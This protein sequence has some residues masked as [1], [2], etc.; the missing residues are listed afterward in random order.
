MY[1][2]CEP[3]FPS[4]LF[5]TIFT[6]IYFKQSFAKTSFDEK[7]QGGAKYLVVTDDS[8]WT[9]VSTI[10]PYEL[11]ENNLPGRNVGEKKR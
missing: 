8:I 2:E 11:H 10:F 4:V 9:F 1:K 7:S 6:F 3:L 5:D